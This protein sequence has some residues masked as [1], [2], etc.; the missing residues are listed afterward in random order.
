MKLQVVQVGQATA[1]PHEVVLANPHATVA[2]LRAVISIKLK[3]DINAFTMRLES[4]ELSDET[5]KL[6][7][8]S[9]DPAG[10]S[11][12]TVVAKRP[13][14][15]D[16]G[17]KH[18]HATNSGNNKPAT[19]AASATAAAAGNQNDAHRLSIL[20][21]LQL[22]SGAGG[23]LNYFT[24]GNNNDGDDDDDE[25]DEEGDFLD[26]DGDYTDEER[27]ELQKMF[28]LVDA[29]PDALRQRVIS[30]PE[31]AMPE[32][33]RF[34]AQL[35]QLASHFPEEFSDAIAGGGPDAMFPFI[36]GE[37]DFNLEDMLFDGF[38]GEG[39]DFDDD[40]DDE[41]EEQPQ[42]HDLRRIAIGGERGRGRGAAAGARGRGRAAATAAP[43]TAAAAAAAT[44][45]A[46]EA[47][48][49]ADRAS[50]ARIVELGFSEQQAIQAFLAMN[51]DADRAAAWL[52]EQR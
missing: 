45:N 46:A 26:M 10:T 17:E 3:L 25:F 31:A 16:E 11:T 2:N 14:D 9:I 47:L 4:Q 33:Q 42:E 13:R 15:D 28:E 35:Y 43:A 24:N 36:D 50:I 34:N 49:A 18:K 48:S 40:D 1:K 37:G 44:T 7:E 29:M 41:A 23:Y 30:D 32:L 22:Q 52:L 38:D 39:A 19:A 8:L 27:E 21:Q 6:S 5:T 51:R 12:I 20:Q